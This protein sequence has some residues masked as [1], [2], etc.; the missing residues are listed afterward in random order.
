MA[1]ATSDNAKLL[2]KPG[3]DV[4]I[5]GNGFSPNMRVI[6]NTTVLSNPADV[7]VDIQKQTI[8]FKLR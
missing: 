7:I 4:V 8:T 6:I 1:N 5:S 3:Q 2:F